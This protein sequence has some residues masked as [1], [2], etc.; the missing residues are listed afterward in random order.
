MLHAIDTIFQSLQ[1]DM[2][3]MEKEC[4]HAVA[5]SFGSSAGRGGKAALEHADSCME[6]RFFLHWDA[7]YT[8]LAPWRLPS[9]ISL[10]CFH[11]GTHA[12]FHRAKLQGSRVPYRR[13]M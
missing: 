6:T 11:C 9:C 13:K 12:M 10:L 4:K 8:Q 7:L 1:R 2:G 3:K 5:F